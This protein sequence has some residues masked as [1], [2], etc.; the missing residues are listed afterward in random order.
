MHLFGDNKTVFIRFFV[1]LL[2]HSSVV[3]RQ[4]RMVFSPLSAAAAPHSK[5]RVKWFYFRQ[6]AC[7]SMETR[8]WVWVGC[9][10]RGCFVDKSWRWRRLEILRRG[11]AWKT[12]HTQYATILSAHCGGTPSLHTLTARRSEH[13]AGLLCLHPHNVQGQP[14]K[15]ECTSWNISTVCWGKMHH[16]YISC[17]Y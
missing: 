12:L 1:P 11:T 3:G 15:L 16:C 5:E 7:I 8:C 4:S 10:R 14:V 9:G 6:Q 2:N 17:I 13:D